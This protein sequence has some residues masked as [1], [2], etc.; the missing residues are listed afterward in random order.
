LRMQYL[1]CSGKRLRAIG[2]FD[3]HHIG[4]ALRSRLLWITMSMH[5]A[6]GTDV[7]GPKSIPWTLLFS[8][9]L[10]LPPPPPPLALSNFI[11]LR[12]L[13]VPL[14][15]SQGRRHSLPLRYSYLPSNLSR[16]H[17]TDPAPRH[18]R[19]MQ[20]GWHLWPAVFTLMGGAQ[21][22]GLARL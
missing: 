5:A 22:K 9:V 13:L 7:L 21:A 16:Y 6:E 10:V 3:Q 20:A 15:S 17:I 2:I 1:A 4:D 19:A 18:R 8:I 11:P 12:S 14:P